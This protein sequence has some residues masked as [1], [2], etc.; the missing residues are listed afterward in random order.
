ME[1]SNPNTSDCGVDEN[2]KPCYH[3][4]QCTNV[5]VV[6]ALAIAFWF[7][8]IYSLNLYSTLSI[9]ETVILIIPIVLF[10]LAM[11]SI[12]HIT[13]RVESTVLKANFFTLG[14]FVALPLITLIKE[15]DMSSKAMFIKIAIVSI[16]FSML[17][18]V[19]VWVNHKYF[20]IQQHIK[21]I[22][23]TYSI[24]L[25]VFAFYRFYGESGSTKSITGVPGEIN[26][27]ATAAVASGVI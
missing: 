9:V 5:R 14:L 7:L 22:M 15:D 17:T 4:N 3:K 25:L 8:I 1:E 12:D 18:L 10:I 19:D 27:S 6:Y 21:S 20:C 2:D 23:Q 24:V 13:V 26:K 11:I 16:M